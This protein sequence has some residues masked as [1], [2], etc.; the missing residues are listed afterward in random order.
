MS[1]N[2]SCDLMN[3]IVSNVKCGVNRIVSF[4]FT[5]LTSIIG[6]PQRVGIYILLCI[7]GDSG[8]DVMND[9]MLGN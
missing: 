1:Q 8:F 2:F 7:L 3:L 4:Y 9:E 6:L 5:G